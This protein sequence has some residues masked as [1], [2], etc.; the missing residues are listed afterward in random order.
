MKKTIKSDEITAQGFVLKKQPYKEKDALLT[1]YFEDYGKL[2][3]LARGILGPKSKNASSCDV[4]CYS[5]FTFLL[6]DGLCP[7]IRAS[8]IKSYA[9]YRIENE[10]CATLVCEYY[11]KQNSD[12]L[13]FKEDSCFLKTVLS[14][15]MD[16]VDVDLVYCFTLVRILK[17]R[18]VMPMVDG[19]VICGTRKAIRGA[20]IQNGGVVCQSHFRMH[21]T[22]MSKE[23]LHLLR[24]VV[25]LDIKDIHKIS[26]TKESLIEVK[27]WLSTF[28]DEHADIVLKTKRFI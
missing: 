17:Q 6:R 25:L 8:F 11:V 13:N 28:F 23:S 7:L 19:C 21:D 15:L 10:A 9:S 18:G 26:Y 3:L 2:T 5:E 24:Q 16:E 27:Q 1:V 12:V 20:S 22:W 14:E 4:L